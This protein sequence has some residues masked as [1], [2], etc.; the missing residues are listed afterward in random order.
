LHE[1]FLALAEQ[2]RDRYLEH[3]SVAADRAEMSIWDTDHTLIGNY[4]VNWT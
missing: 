1:Q 4:P 2:F 3:F